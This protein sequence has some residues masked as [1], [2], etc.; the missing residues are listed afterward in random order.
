MILFNVFLSI[1]VVF[2]ISL[3]IGAITSAGRSES[4]AATLRRGFMTII[5]LAVLVIAF[6]A[7]TDNPTILDRIM[8]YFEMLLN[9]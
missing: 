5:F 2:V 4:F 7:I 1:T 6:F 8:E 9:Y 3:I